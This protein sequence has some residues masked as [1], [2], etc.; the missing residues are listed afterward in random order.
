MRDNANYNDLVD[1]MSK[2]LG[3]D[4]AKK[5]RMRYTMG[6]N[7]TQMEIRNDMDI[8]FFLWNWKDVKQIVR[9]Q[10]A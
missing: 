9:I 3:I 1:G 7:L 2:K 6:V 10:Y 5:I 8:I 4:C